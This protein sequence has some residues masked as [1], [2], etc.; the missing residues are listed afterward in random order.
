M[1]NWCENSVTING[2]NLTPLREAIGDGTGLMTRFFPMPKA[3]EGSISPFNG[4][5]EE[6]AKLIELYGCNN[7]YDWKVKNWGTKWDV[8]ASVGKP[9]D[10]SIYLRFDSAWGPPLEGMAKISRLFPDVTI[11]H[12]YFEPGM[13]FVGVAEI[14][15]GEIEDAYSDDPDSDDWK[16]MAAD[17]FGWEPEI[18]EEDDVSI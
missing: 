15:N 10:G 6:S 2:E 7:W 1:P 5:P 8:D 3:L 14:S 9:D 12:A 13:C 11:R 18:D 16:K 17:E 4:T